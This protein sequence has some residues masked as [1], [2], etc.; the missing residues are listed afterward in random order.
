MNKQ[1]LAHLR[2][3]SLCF[4]I[5]CVACTNA[6]ACVIPGAGSSI[7]FEQVPTDPRF[8]SSEIIEASVYDR[9]RVE[10]A[11]SGYQVELLTAR[12]DHVVKGSTNTETVKI[13]LHPGCPI[14]GYNGHGIILGELQDD[15]QLGLVLIPKE[16]GLREPL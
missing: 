11:G 9:T 14:V 7:L 13:L 2:T 15:P 16:H 10:R 4:A 8:S 3:W 12:V 6:V 1:P 5:Y